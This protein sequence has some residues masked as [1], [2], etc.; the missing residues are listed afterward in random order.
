MASSPSKPYDGQIVDVQAH[1][2]KQSSYD[3]IASA[4]R[5]TFSLTDGAIEVITNDV[6]NNLADDLRGDDLRKAIGRDG[7]QVV[8]VNTIFPILRP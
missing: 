3:A 4:V 8:T 6:C 7:P 5:A 2:I 1:A